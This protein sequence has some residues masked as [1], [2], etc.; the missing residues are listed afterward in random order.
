MYLEKRGRSPFSAEK[1]SP[2]GGH[3]EKPTA[4]I[5]VDSPWNSVCQVHHHPC[6]IL[7]KC[8]RKGLNVRLRSLDLILKVLG[9]IRVLSRE[10]HGRMKF[11]I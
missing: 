5:P 10:G 6:L 3:Q 4:Q 11:T 8:H 9:A 2:K 1:M 7:A